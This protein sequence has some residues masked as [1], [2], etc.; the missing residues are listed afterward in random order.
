M[1]VVLLYEPQ[2]RP[3]GWFDDQLTPIGWFDEELVEPVSGFG[4][5]A[6]IYEPQYVVEGWFDDQATNVSWFDEEL[7]VLPVAAQF[8]VH[9]ASP[10]LD[11]LDA[12]VVPSE[13]ATPVH[14]GGIG[15]PGELPKIFID[16]VV[17][18]SAR[19]FDVLDAV[20]VP[21][22]VV[23]EIFGIAPGQVVDPEPLPAISRGQ[24]GPEPGP[25]ADVKDWRKYNE[26]LLLL[27]E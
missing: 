4:V 22:G 5:F 15:G 18:E 17:V 20:V 8:V 7:G 21:Q 25:A 14:W 19:A 1:A 3:Q 16:A 26:E 10:A 9:E 11:D 2:Y 24:A 13:E 12:E 23:L 6:P 27:I